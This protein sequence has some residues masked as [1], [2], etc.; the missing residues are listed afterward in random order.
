[1]SSFVLRQLG[2]TEYGVYQTISSFVNY[3]VLLE[4]GTGTAMVRN[5]SACR[6][7][8]DS[9]L[10]K[11][12]NIAT[13]WTIANGLAMVMA[14]VSVVFFVLLDDIYASS[15]TASQIASGKAMFAF[16]VVSRPRHCQS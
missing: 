9:Q 12:R 4:F 2:S 6:A 11:E 15:L 7:N 3:L 16:I 1:M 8:G 14:V 5:L 10:V 13:I